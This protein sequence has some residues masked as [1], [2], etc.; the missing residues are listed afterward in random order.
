MNGPVELI[1]AVASGLPAPRYA[2]IGVVFVRATA[3]SH[4][5]ASNRYVPGDMRRVPP[6]RNAPTLG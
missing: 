2:P 4:W 6:G 1:G 3:T 5:T